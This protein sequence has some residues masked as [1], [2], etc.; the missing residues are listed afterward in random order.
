M[1]VQNILKDALNIYHYGSYVYGTFQEGKSD[2]DFIVV[3]PNEYNIES[4]FIE[5]NNCQYSLYTLD[6]WENKLHNH[7]VDAIETYFLPDKYRI[8]ETVHTIINI[9]PEK[10]RESFSRTASNSWV[11]C[12]K[13]LEVMESFN[14]RI[15]KKSLWHS[16]RIID[17][18]TQ[19]ML[20]G[21]IVNYG[22]MNHIYSQ[23]VDCPNDYYSFYKARYQ[24]CYNSMKTIFRQAS[25]LASWFKNNHKGV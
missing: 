2:M 12:K 11:K 17:F 22:S 13:K 19:I 23:I 20:N 15:A 14:P 8:K 9:N 3:L 25:D 18:G 10:L 24:Q 6:Q 1:N 21:R 5:D 4:D 16:L 7:D